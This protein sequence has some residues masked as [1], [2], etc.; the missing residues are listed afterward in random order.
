MIP[1]YEGKEPYIFVSYA[2]KDSSVVF[3]LV[4]ATESG[5]T[6]A[7]SPA[8]NGP[9]TSPTTCWARKWCSQFSPPAQ[10]TA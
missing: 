10:L 7:S 1:A 6:R 8:Q 9:N 3:R 5:T 4:E 2:H